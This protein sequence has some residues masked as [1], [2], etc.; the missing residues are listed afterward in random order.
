[1]YWVVGAVPGCSPTGSAVVYG[2][3]ITV[4]WTQVTLKGVW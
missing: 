2:Y 1:M 3:G 4:G